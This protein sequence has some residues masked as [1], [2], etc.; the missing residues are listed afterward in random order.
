VGEQEEK[1]GGDLYYLAFFADHSMFLDVW[2]L[3]Y[4][5]KCSKLDL[6]T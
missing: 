4:V 6:P 5:K 1:Q 2:N 3:F